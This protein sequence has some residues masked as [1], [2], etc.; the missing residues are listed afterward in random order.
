MN[1]TAT[2]IFDTR[3][4]VSKPSKILSAEGYTERE[5]KLPTV[6]RLRTYLSTFTTIL[7]TG[8]EAGQDQFIQTYQD[9]ASKPMAVCASGLKQD[10]EAVKNCLR[11]PTIC[12]GPMERTHNKT[13]MVR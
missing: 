9:D 12:N 2:I 4:D 11:Y 1:G 7:D 3:S 6:A 5:A 8:D 13:T 10:I